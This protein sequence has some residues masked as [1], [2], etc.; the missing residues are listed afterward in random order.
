M[1]NKDNRP[2]QH[3]LVATTV[4]SD[5][6]ATCSMGDLGTGARAAGDEVQL[7]SYGLRYQT[8]HQL[9]RGGMASV[10][11][12]YDPVLGRHVA[13]KL[14]NPALVRQRGELE[15]FV[16]EAR[17]T[18]QLDHPNIV[19]VYELASGP[20]GDFACFA[21]KL[22]E[23]ESLAERF[24]RLGDRRLSP[25]ELPGLLDV[26]LK[27]CD[28]VSYAHSRGVLH[29]DLK[30]QNVMIGGWGQVYVMDWGIAVRC[31]R[32]A[33]GL[34]HPIEQHESVRGT[35]AYMAPEQLERELRG[36]DQRA[37][38]YGLGAI[39]YQLLT[40]HP[41]FEVR[42]DDDTDVQRLREH[43]VSDPLAGPERQ[44]IPP[45]LARVAMRALA[46][47]PDQRFSSIDELRS[48]LELL[49]RGGGWFNARRFA[50]GELIVSEGDPAEEGY[51]LV[52]GECD[53]FK[54]SGDESLHLRRMQSGDVFG[55]IGIFTRGSRSATVRAV[56]AVT[57]LVVTRETFDLELSALGWLGLFV[58]ALASRFREADDEL[59]ALRIKQ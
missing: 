31:R 21:M 37:D 4:S 57:V 11:H 2:R 22:V 15:A 32:G 46:P 26:L 36:V 42:G 48:E 59:A 9:A 41:P 19:P 14:L 12:A 44:G 5:R 43:V 24:M 3:E 58:R 23:G 20:T 27:I 10:V 38:V 13:V 8:Q 39:I 52:E 51:I 7:E 45:G 33:D 53:V 35:F 6:D 54:Q 49:V 56:S 50:P 30:P 29:L 1:V 28:G 34:L 16:R 40:G 47:E 55:E 18:A 17:V 25:A